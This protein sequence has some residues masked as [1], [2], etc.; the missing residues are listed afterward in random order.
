[1]ESG[2]FS[3]WCSRQCWQ[4]PSRKRTP[5]S[6]SVTGTTENQE[7]NT[8]VKGQR[9]QTVEHFT[10]LGSTLSRSANINAKVN[11]RFAKASSAFGRL[12]KTAWEWRGISQRTRIKLYTAVVLTT[13]FVRI[14]NLDHLQATRKTTPA[15]PSPVSSPYPQD[16]LAG[17]DS[18]QWGAGEGRPPE[19]RHHHA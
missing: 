19:H 14:W 13:P 9:L 3:V 12:T 5:L 16:P 2:R 17:Q 1:M 4:M 7:P 15:V 10:Y 18:R 11:S 6:P 8:T